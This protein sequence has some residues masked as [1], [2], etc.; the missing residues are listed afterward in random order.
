[1]TN[2]QKMQHSQNQLGNHNQKNSNNEAKKKGMVFSAYLSFYKLNYLR[3]CLSMD[4]GD[5]TQTHNVCIHHNVW[6]LEDV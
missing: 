4:N 3:N 5:H 6:I 2:V 1:M